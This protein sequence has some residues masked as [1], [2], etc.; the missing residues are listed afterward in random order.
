MNI[1]RKMMAVGFV[2]FLASPAVSGR[3]P[4]SGKNIRIEVQMETAGS[5]REGFYQADHQSKSTQLL[6]VADGLEGRLFIGEQVPYA[7][8]YQT[9][10]YNEGYVTGTNIQFRNVGTS[11]I[12][13]PRITGN[14]IEVTLTPEISYETRDGRGT[15]AVTKLSSTV[16]VMNGQSIQVGGGARKTEF[17][18]NFYT[19]ETGE[20][21]RVILTPT[22][23]EG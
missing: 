8:W 19:R 21:V 16:R 20:A 6:L 12:V 7:V 4:V 11:L 22:V 23:L 9:Y 1:R 10:L 18:N 3:L 17:E 5:V 13:T 14:Q 2:L 15:I